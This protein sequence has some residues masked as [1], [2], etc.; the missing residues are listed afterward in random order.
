MHYISTVY[1]R[2]QSR[3][4]F[5][6]WLSIQNWQFKHRYLCALQPLSDINIE[7]QDDIARAIDEHFGAFFLWMLYGL[8]AKLCENDPGII[9]VSHEVYFDTA[10][11]HFTPLST[12]QSLTTVQALLLLIVYTFRHT[13][14]ELSLWHTGG[15]AIRSAIELGLHRKIRLKDIR[16]SDP[17]A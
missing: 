8:G 3:Y 5:L 7:Q 13:S 15:L 11:R 4:G 1:Y 17:R 10:L 9:P 12:I 14:S 16:E 6:D 2:I